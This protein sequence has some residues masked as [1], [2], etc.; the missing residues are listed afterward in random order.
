MLLHTH[1]L[2]AKGSPVYVY[3]NERTHLHGWVARRGE[4]KPIQH[5]FA[6]N[7]HAHTCSH[8][9][10]RHPGSQAARICEIRANNVLGKLCENCYIYYIRSPKHLIWF[11]MLHS[12][13]KVLSSSSSCWQRHWIGAKWQRWELKSV[14]FRPQINMKGETNSESLGLGTEGR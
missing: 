8:R 1:S 6:A 5:P 7:S 10:S 11:L 4:G 12:L 13:Q 2:H 14:E 3:E 9:S